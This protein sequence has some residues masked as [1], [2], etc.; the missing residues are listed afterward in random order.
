MLVI[1]ITNIFYKKTNKMTKKWLNVIISEPDNSMHILDAYDY[2]EHGYEEVKKELNVKGANII[3]V[4]SR[5]PG[6]TEYVY[7]AIHE[8][9]AIHELLSNKEKRIAQDV[10]EN[11]TKTMNRNL[12]IQEMNKWVEAD[13]SVLA[14]R[15]LLIRIK[16]IQDKWT[17][18]LTGLEQLHYQVAKI[19]DLKKLGLDEATI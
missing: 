8:L 2:F 19:A 7:A 14:Y 5:V 13:E 11:L 6:L 4:S 17:G 3:S 1:N 12:G 10:R 16:L 18:V 9:K 15:E